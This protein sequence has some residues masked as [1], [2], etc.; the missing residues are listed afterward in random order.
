MKIS[1]RVDIVLALVVKRL[2]IKEEG[3]VEV[4]RSFFLNKK[5]KYIEER[6][7]VKVARLLA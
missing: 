5:M 4:K 1:G 7:L 2:I 6:K 3:K